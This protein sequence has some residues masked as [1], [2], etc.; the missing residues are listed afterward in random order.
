MMAFFKETKKDSDSP[1]GD[2]N[3][4]EDH[5]SKAEHNFSSETIYDYETSSVEVSVKSE[6]LSAEIQK[7][8]VT[9][10][11]SSAAI[12]GTLEADGDVQ[13]EGTLEGDAICKANL[14]VTGAVNGSVNANTLIVDGATIHGDVNCLSSVH[15]LNNAHIVGNITAAD[16][17]VSGKI[18]GNLSVQNNIYLDSTA[19]VTGDITA[20]EIE[21]KPGAAI[22]GTCHIGSNAVLEEQSKDMISA[23]VSSEL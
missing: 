14:T 7:V 3:L 10:I 6:A 1:S 23:A 5:F 17:S 16:A 9:A 8:P 15:L 12:R 11:L 19:S 2:L 21:V 20:V 22:I 4:I 13:I 18:T